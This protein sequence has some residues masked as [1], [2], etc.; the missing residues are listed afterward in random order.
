MG[1]EEWG[2]DA[3]RK[4]SAPWERRI[5]VRLLR[6]RI[7]SGYFVAP[8]PCPGIVRDYFVVGSGTSLFAAGT[9]PSTWVKRSGTPRIQL[10]TA[11][12]NTPVIF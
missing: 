2:A 6:C 12:P 8:F 4:R 7:K 11:P 5:F 1:Y 9:V 10:K 3:A